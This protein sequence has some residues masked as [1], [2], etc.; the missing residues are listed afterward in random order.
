MKKVFTILGAFVA[1]I[2]VAVGIAAAIFIPRALKLDREAVAYINQ[3]VPEIVSHWNSQEF[4][5]RATP[6]CLKAGG[7]REKIDQIFKWFQQL[8]AFEHLDEPRG[9]IT[10]GTDGTLGNYTAQAKFEKGPA[11]I[12]IQLRRVNDSWKINCFRVVSD[13]LLPT[14]A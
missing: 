9:M 2:L 10:S 7:S 12:E 4:V 1:V 14:K 11:R 13:A 5:A 3:S 8:G 6:E